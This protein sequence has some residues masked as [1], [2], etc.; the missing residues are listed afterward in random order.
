MFN[1]ENFRLRGHWKNDR[2]ISAASP[3]QASF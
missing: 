2:P 1:V 3:D